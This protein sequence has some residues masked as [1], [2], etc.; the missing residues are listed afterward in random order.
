MNDIFNA[1]N[2]IDSLSK[3]SDFNKYRIFHLSCHGIDTD[4]YIVEQGYERLD[5]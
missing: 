4:K 1:V 3:C 5:P 2:E